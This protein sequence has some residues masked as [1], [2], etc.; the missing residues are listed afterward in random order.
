MIKLTSSEY[1]NSL[2]TLNSGLA[3]QCYENI[4]HFIF[5]VR[6][7][8]TVPVQKVTAQGGRR[9]QLECNVEGFPRPE[10]SWEFSSERG[11]LGVAIHTGGRYIKEEFLLSAD[12][13]RTVLTINE[14][15]KS[16]R[17]Y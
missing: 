10:I 1:H 17:T 5:A 8:V 15:S 16:V 13:T 2:K 14:F 11:E 6:P 12:S 4:F 3:T 9:V 7:I